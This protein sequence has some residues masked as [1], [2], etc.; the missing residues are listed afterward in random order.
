ML[1]IRNKIL[2]KRVLFM[3]NYLVISSIRKFLRCILGC[4][5]A[6]VLY[7]FRMLYRVVLGAVLGVLFA[8]KTLIINMLN[9]IHTFVFA[10]E[11]MYLC[12][13]K[14][15]YYGRSTYR[16]SANDNANPVR[17]ATGC[18]SIICAG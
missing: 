11:N 4:V 2:D 15:P 13:A 7:S 16:Y 18:R 6:F 8:P 3:C 12:I 17:D 10:I 9:S 14:V 5:T 1:K